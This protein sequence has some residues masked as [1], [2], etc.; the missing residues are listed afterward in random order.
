MPEAELVSGQPAL[1]H[2]TTRVPKATR[3]EPVASM[4]ARL[5][6]ATFEC[7]DDV[8]V[9]DGHRLVG[10]VAIERLL[11]ASESTSIEQLM[12]PD[13]PVVAPGSDQEAV[14][15]EMVRRG[16]SSVAVIDS[17]GSFVGL[18]PPHRMIGALLAEHDEDL[19]RL[20]GYLS[21]ASQARQAIEES[22]LRRLWH[23]LPWLLVGLAGAMLSAVL[24]GAFE[25]E[26]KANVLLAIFIPAIV[27]MAAAVGN[28]TQTLLIRGLSAGIDVRAVAQRE[29]GTGIVIGLLL[30][31]AF[32]P[33]AWVAWDDGPVAWS[34]SIALFASSAMATL[35]AIALP[36]LLHHWGRDPAFGSGPLGTVLQDLVSIITYFVVAA[37]LLT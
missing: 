11:A 35:I 23:R 15:W 9:L 14:A 30:G 10:L 13:P 17:H 2:A 32:L 7:A 24:V 28:Q 20:G 26:L 29:L 22:L 21:R 27:Y 4:R 8:V 19:A 25:D 1:A 16:E 33:F 3:D 6:G 37:L 36:W 12:D 5:V 18:V 31:I 34:V